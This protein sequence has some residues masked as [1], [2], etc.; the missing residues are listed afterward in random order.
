MCRLF[1][2]IRIDDGKIQ[3]LVGHEERMTR[4]R[5]ELW[6]ITAPV[7]LSLILTVPVEWKKGVVRCNIYYD[8]EIGPIQFAKYIQNPVRSLRIVES[9]DISYHLKFCDRTKLDQLL[10]LKQGCDEI[11]IVRN[12]LV[13]DSTISNLIFYDGFQWF[14]PTSPLLN[15]TCRQR[16]L[17]EKRI[18]EKE[19]YFKDIFT[20]AGVK[21]I[22]ALRDPENGE[23]IPIV[24]IIM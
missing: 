3:N 9:D 24:N 8:H 13:T 19:I 23:L 15:G 11:I 12:G 4:S 2:T 16:L 6:N 22:N 1:E 21:L 18:F 14:T 10:S 20:F 17:Q 5:K 7:D